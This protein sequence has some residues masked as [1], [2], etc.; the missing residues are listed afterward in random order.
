MFCKEDSEIEEIATNGVIDS[1]IEIAMDMAVCMMTK[2]VL[3]N[4]R[5]S[6]VYVE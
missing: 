5:F 4:L 3:V 2:E 1:V 6:S